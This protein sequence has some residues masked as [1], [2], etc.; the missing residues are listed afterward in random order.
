M[1]RRSS[2]ARTRFSASART[3]GLPRRATRCCSS[4]HISSSGRGALGT[5]S[6]SLKPSPR[7]FTSS[8]SRHEVLAC[9]ARA[10]IVRLGA[11]H[12]AADVLDDELQPA[13]EALGTALH[14]DELAGVELFTEPL[15]AVQG[16]PDDLARGV[17]Q[18]QRDV[19]AAASRADGLV[20]AE[21]ESPA[22]L[23][24][25]QAVG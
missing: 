15:D 21:E 3:C 9:E 24:G 13:V 11:E 5:N 4:A 17:L 22:R 2:W 10:A 7:S 25:G 23:V 6:S 18:R 8:P 20:G 14:L 19:V 1:R 16:T 12:H